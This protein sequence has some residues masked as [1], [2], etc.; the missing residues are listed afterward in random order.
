M[1]KR[2]C[3]CKTEKDEQD[4]HRNSAS[5]DGLHGECKDCAKQIRR[6]QY[7]D[8]PDLLRE[9]NLLR[10]FGIG[11]QEYNKLH[12]SQ[13]GCC[14]ICKKKLETLSVDHDHTTGAIRGLLCPQ[15]N[16]GIGNFLNDIGLLKSAIAY[17]EEAPKKMHLE[18]G[19]MRL[20]YKHRKDRC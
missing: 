4:F 12:A 13:G 10:Y 1:A 15:C 3:K 17:L 18:H 8:N 9:A 11:I 2:C 20:L 16:F 5:K 19:L 6:D 7:K 14:A